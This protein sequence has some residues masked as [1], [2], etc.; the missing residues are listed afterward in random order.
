[1]TTRYYQLVQV[2]Y[3][4]HGCLKTGR[5]FKFFASRCIWWAK[6]II[7]DTNVIFTVLRRRR[8]VIGPL[9]KTRRST[10]NAHD[11]VYASAWS[12]RCVNAGP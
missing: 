1:M 3:G 6:N 9:T 10:I 7:F 8:A 11:Y 5:L 2:S 4:I 12:L